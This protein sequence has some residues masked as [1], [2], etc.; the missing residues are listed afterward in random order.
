MRAGIATLDG[1]LKG[2]VYETLK[3][4]AERFFALL[5]K[6]IEGFPVSL[7]RNGFMFTLF[8]RKDAPRCYS[9]VKECD[10]ELFGAW[11]RFML[12][13][14]FYVSPSQFETDFLSAA[15]DD[16]KLAEMAEATGEFLRGFY[17]A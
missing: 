1:L 14:G 9:E 5:E 6:S 4:K 13:H 12:D 11:F 3:S 8:F 16:E 10:F 2:S 7:S 17:G 15:H